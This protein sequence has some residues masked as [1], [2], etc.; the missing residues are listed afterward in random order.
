MTLIWPD[1]NFQPIGGGIVAGDAQPDAP[2]VELGPEDPETGLPK[3]SIS[4][5]HESQHKFGE[6]PVHIRKFKIVQEIAFG[7]TTNRAD[8]AAAI[9]TQQGSPHP[10]FGGASCTELTSSETVEETETGKKLIT[11]ITAVYT[12]S[13]DAAGIHP[14]NKPDIW[15]FKTQG[16]AVAA[17]FSFNGNSTEPLTNSA[18]DYIKGL[19]VDEAQTKVMIKGNR[20]TFPSATATALT[21]CVN[22]GAFLGGA[23]NHWKCQGI[24]GELKYESWNNT[25]VRFWEVTVELLYRQTGWNLLIPDIGFNYIEGG[26]KKRAMVFDDQNKEWVAS[27]EPV[28]LDGNGAMAGG[29]NAPAVLNRRIYRQANFS[30]Y[31]GS[32]Y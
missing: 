1:P 12:V 15:S 17:F 9:N 11:E 18:G 20:A 3:Y 16:A 2:I 19:Q 27:A 24:T 31:F 14:L 25:V 30:T 7:E 28:A 13:K 4:T 5:T 22:A 32:P 6:P 8:I 26:Q 10:V 23:E 29:G 21:N